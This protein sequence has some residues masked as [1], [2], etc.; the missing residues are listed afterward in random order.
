M[1]KTIFSLYSN[2][3]LD[4]FIGLELNK[5]PQNS[6]NNFALKNCLFGTV[7][8]VRN[9][10][11]GKFTY[12]GTG[13]AFDGEDSKSLCNV[14]AR[15]VIIFDVNN[16]SSSHINNRK[17]NFLV[18]GEGPTEVALVRQKKI[19]VNFSKANTKFLLSLH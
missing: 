5:W 11:K 4:L 14:Y 6:S 1:Q 3:I 8:L 18:L 17:N 10:I 13:I 9:A 7:K 16:C 2:L 12:N 15:N 19:T